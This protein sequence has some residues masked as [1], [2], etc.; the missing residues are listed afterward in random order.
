MKS[1]HNGESWQHP[2]WSHSLHPEW[3][4]TA[5][6]LNGAIWRAPL[7]NVW[8]IPRK[9]SQNPRGLLFKIWGPEGELPRPSSTETLQARPP[10]L[11]TLGPNKQLAHHRWRNKAIVAF[12]L[13]STVSQK[14]P[15]NVLMKTTERKP[16]GPTHRR[17]G[18]HSR[19]W[20]ESTRMKVVQQAPRAHR[21]CIWGGGALERRK[22]S[23]PLEAHHADAIPPR[24]ANE[25]LVNK[26]KGVAVDLFGKQLHHAC[27]RFYYFQ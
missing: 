5:S 6:T 8:R 9:A 4:A 16:W 12:C 13:S 24:T 22:R 18:G 20:W 26:R 27:S 3:R 2:A 23:V 11:R 1:Q 17:R 14:L 21:S 7:R 25:A 10:K 19:R 15:E